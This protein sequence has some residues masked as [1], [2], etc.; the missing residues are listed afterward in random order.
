MPAS[1]NVRGQI[2]CLYAC[3][4]VAGLCKQRSDPHVVPSSFQSF[5][6]LF[7]PNKVF[8]IVLLSISIFNII[9]LFPNHGNDFNAGCYTTSMEVTPRGMWNLW[10]LYGL[11][12]SF[13]N[14]YKYLQYL[15]FESQTQDSHQF[16]SNI[17]QYLQQLS[18][19]IQSQDFHQISHQEFGHIKTYTGYIEH[20]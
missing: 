6:C 18:F 4:V 5:H 8:I 17:Y 13:F 7:D 9:F 16:L 14:I 19:K 3:A 12:F 15:S 20:V 1:C 2:L 11:A 10:I